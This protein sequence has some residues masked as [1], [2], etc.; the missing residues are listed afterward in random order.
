M[1]K[2]RVDKILELIKDI[3]KLELQELANRLEKE[4]HIHV[5]FV[6]PTQYVE[7]FSGRLLK[8]IEVVKDEKSLS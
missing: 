6:I 4:Y 8:E 3:E 7:G 1:K 2:T 5:S